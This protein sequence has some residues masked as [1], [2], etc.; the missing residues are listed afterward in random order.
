MAIGKDEAGIA[1][2]P[3]LTFRITVTPYPLQSLFDW[4]TMHLWRALAALLFPAF[5]IM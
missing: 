4:G 5:P 2:T 3:Y 1:A